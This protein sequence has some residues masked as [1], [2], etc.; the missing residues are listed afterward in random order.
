MSQSPGRRSRSARAR[1][2]VLLDRDVCRWV[3][4]CVPLPVE[5]FWPFLRGLSLHLL[6]FFGAGIPTTATLPP[7]MRL[8]ARRRPQAS[9]AGCLSVRHS[10]CFASKFT[11]M[12]G[13]TSGSLKS[14]ATRRAEQPVGGGRRYLPPP[15]SHLS[16]FHHHHPPPPTTHTARRLA[17]R[18]LASSHRPLHLHSAHPSH[19]PSPWGAFRGDFTVR[20]PRWQP[21]EKR[22]P[23]SLAARCRFGQPPTQA[24]LIRDTPSFFRPA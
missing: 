18:P 16:A 10:R 14:M 1:A 12:V 4:S 15:A 23:E 19:T 8:G 3:A 13:A 21:S 7:S 2:R 17:S 11:C 6:T 9:P 5:P 20:P 22:S 24:I